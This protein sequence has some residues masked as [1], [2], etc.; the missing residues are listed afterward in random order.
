M[1]EKVDYDSIDWKRE[2]VLYRGNC[3]H[4]LEEQLVRCWA[5][6]ER[7]RYCGRAEENSEY[8]TFVS[9]LASDGF[10]Y[11]SRSI[12]HLKMNKNV[13]PSL[14]LSPFTQYPFVMAISAIPYRDKIFRSDKGEG[15][16][17]AGSIDVEDIVPIFGLGIQNDSALSQNEYLESYY[18][19]RLLLRDI[20]ELSGWLS[21]EPFLERFKKEGTK[22]D[23]LMRLVF[24]S[25]PRYDR[26]ERESVRRAV[27]K[28]ER[29]YARRDFDSSLDK[30]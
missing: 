14:L 23:P 20:S 9:S 22:M 2:G 12:N 21:K 18:Q 6:G 27:K 17:I 16:F 29:F 15:L 11:A 8:I 5:R 1:I 7:G 3:Q 26:K 30:K 24:G 13:M 4:L 28:L 19:R 25:K 10:C